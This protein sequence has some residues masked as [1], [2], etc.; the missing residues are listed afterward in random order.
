ML[1]KRHA[2]PRAVHLLYDGPV[3]QLLVRLGVQA[4][5]GIRRLLP[6]ES[7]GSGNFGKMIAHV[8]RFHSAAFSLGEHQ[9][10]ENTG[11]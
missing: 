3:N 9:E 8:Y 5:G 2:G 6:G 7:A 11:N 4:F 10:L 1:R